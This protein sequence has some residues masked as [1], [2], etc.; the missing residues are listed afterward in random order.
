[1]LDLY[2][3]HS[4]I[5]AQITSQLLY[6]LGAE[7]F[8]RVLSNRKYLARTKAMQ[9]RMNISILE[10]WARTNNRQPEHFEHGEMKST[11]EK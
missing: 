1:M 6:W 8:N 4:V 3:I 10:D 2:D 11:G 7:L 9:I 5:T